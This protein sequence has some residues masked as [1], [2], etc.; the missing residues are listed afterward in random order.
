MLPNTIRGD[1]DS[2]KHFIFFKVM[3][4]R[5][6]EHPIINSDSPIST[7]NDNFFITHI[8]Q[9]LNDTDSFMQ[10]ITKKYYKLVFF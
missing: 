10:Y 1:L 2:L 8:N 6:N 9:T 3:I 7:N 5:A 4:D